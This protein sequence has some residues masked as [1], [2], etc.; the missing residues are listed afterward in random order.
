MDVCDGFA[1][2]FIAVIG[3]PLILASS[4][5]LVEGYWGFGTMIYTVFICYKWYVVLFDSGF[6]FKLLRNGIL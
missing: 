1:F 4:V 3:F 6:R 2:P 5:E